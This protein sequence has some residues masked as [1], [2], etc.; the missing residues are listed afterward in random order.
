ML[1][2]AL[3]SSY[4]SWTMMEILADYFKTIIDKRKEKYIRSSIVDT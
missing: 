1:R 3:I 4:K 2:I